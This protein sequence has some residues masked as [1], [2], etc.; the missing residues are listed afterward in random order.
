MP[1]QMSVCTP[2]HLHLC[3]SPSIFLS[4]PPSLCHPPSVTLA[5]SVSQTHQPLILWF[6]CPASMMLQLLRADVCH[7]CWS[8]EI[9]L[10]PS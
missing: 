9:V 4:L 3:L 1:E 7:V 8:V 10:H 2:I 6:P 5:L